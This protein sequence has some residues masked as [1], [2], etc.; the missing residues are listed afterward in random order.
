MCPKYGSLSDR[1]DDSK[2]GPESIGECII[3]NHQKYEPSM[4]F[5]ERD[6]TEHD[7]QQLKNAFLTMGFVVSQYDNRSV[8]QIFEILSNGM[9]ITFNNSFDS[10][11]EAYDAPQL[12]R[13]PSYD[14]PCKF[15][16]SVSTGS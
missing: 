1:N 5:S 2:Q 9:S 13:S 16:F 15:F 3:F 7:A 14:R 6:G 4:G 10:Y 12:I 8:S 11:G